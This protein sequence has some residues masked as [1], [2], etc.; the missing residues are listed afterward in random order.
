MSKIESISAEAPLHGGSVE[1]V[2]YTDPLC[3]WSWA[4]EPQW[5]KLRYEYEGVFTWKYRMAGMIPDWNSYNDPLN[6]VTR[7]QHM[8]PLWMEAEQVSGMPINSRIWVD[9]PPQSSVPACVAVKCA[10][11]QSTAI[12]EAYLRKLREAVMI[13]GKNIGKKETLWEQAKELALEMAIFDYDLFVKAYSSDLCIAAFKEDIA[14]VRYYA[15]QR[16]PTLV[17]SG[18]N[19]R[20][21]MI[22][23]YK[24]YEALVEALKQVVPDLSP[25][26]KANGI[27]DYK[28]YWAGI[29]DREVEEA[30]G[31]VRQS[32]EQ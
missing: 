21:V 22:S 13:Y 17:L 11:L 14:S 26:R 10:T 32:S 24:P 15:I 1:I 8:G 16:F 6:S 4:L 25:T 12:G 5:R 9:D 2:Y 29:T 19:K 7:P 3:C 30:L 28:D 23:G 31:I 18:E 20:S 27:Q